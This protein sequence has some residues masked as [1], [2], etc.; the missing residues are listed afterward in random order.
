MQ[1]INAIIETKL[2]INET[3]FISVT[4]DITDSYKLP[5]V[6]K[7]C[8]WKYVYVEDVEPMP[9]SSGV[10]FL[11]PQKLHFFECNGNVY[12]RVNG[13]LL[14]LISRNGETKNMKLSEILVLNPDFPKEENLDILIHRRQTYTYSQFDYVT[15]HSETFFGAWRHF[16]KKMNSTSD[17]KKQKKI[18]NEFLDL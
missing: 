17:I 5:N 6:L 8:I 18:L 11:R 4:V 1:E 10:N 15:T 7:D 14:H 12:K 16:T 3:D 9:P 13:D 2:D